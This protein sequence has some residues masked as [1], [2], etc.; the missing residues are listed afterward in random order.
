M[1]KRS[2]VI[3][4]LLLSLTLVTSCSSM[5]Y[6][7][8][9]SSRKSNDQKNINRVPSQQVTPEGYKNFL[10]LLMGKEWGVECMS[11]KF[12]YG[13]AFRSNDYE[14]VRNKIWLSM[15]IPHSSFVFESE[16]GTEKIWFK[17]FFKD[18]WSGN[19]W[20]LT[21]NEWLQ[22]PLDKWGGNSWELKPQEVSFLSN[23]QLEIIVDDGGIFRGKKSVVFT[24]SSSSPNKLLGILYHE[25]SG[26]APCIMEVKE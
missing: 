12:I 16:P 20:E 21:Q 11:I 24:P 14:I 6:K 18:K 7:R 19:W 8:V 13:S 4:Y 23:E 3:I 22:G 17:G 1:K 9:T 5:D 26:M 15:T 10:T 2:L 25:N